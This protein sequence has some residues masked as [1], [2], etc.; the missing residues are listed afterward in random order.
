VVKKPKPVSAEKKSVVKK[1]KPVSA[2]KKPA[3]KRKPSE[4]LFYFSKRNKELKAAGVKDFS[5]R[6]QRISRQWME[7]KAIRVPLPEVTEEQL[8]ELS[9]GGEWDW[10]EEQEWEKKNKF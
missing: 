5:E 7:K 2:E 1:P 6:R 4:Y 9:D 8:A 3:K 10:P